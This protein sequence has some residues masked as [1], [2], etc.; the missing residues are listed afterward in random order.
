MLYNNYGG[1]VENVQIRCKK[2]TGSFWLK[3][4]LIYCL[5]IKEKLPIYLLVFTT[6]PHNYILYGI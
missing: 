6:V 1:D 2:G 3:K 5:R 4:N